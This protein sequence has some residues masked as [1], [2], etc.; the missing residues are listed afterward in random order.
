MTR[1]L[2]LAM[3]L[4]GCL[5]VEGKSVSPQA[6]EAV[7]TI[8]ELRAIGLPNFEAGENGPPAR[9]PGLLRRLNK[10]LRTLITN[11][12][13]DP[14]RSGVASEHEITAEL[15]AAGWREIPRYKW[16]AYGEISQIRFDLR[17]GFEPD[18]L[19]V[20]T[21][22]WVP[23][24]DT[25]PDTAIYVFQGRARNWKLVLATDAD[26]DPGGARKAIGMEYSLSPAD[27]HGNW[28]LAIAQA[29]PACGPTPAPASLRYRILRPGPSPDEPRVLLDRSESV[30]EKFSRHSVW[31]CRMTGLP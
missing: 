26:F 5:P 17:G 4:L 11:T 9:V 21:E 29:P 31:K 2:I 25:D 3:T 10:Q 23:C 30:N 7:Q 14:N 28:Y 18:I 24:G 16:N 12:L 1:F 13:N 20:S 22:L 15:Q 8:Q 6:Q 27:A 19:I